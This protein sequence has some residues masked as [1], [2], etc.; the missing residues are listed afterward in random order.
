VSSL[1][2]FSSSLFQIRFQKT[3]RHFLD[4]RILVTPQPGRPRQIK[5]QIAM[6]DRPMIP[7]ADI[8]EQ[9]DAGR[10]RSGIY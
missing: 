3:F 10:N 4:A 6:L 8:V 7:F 9:Q 2:E 5:F 1:R